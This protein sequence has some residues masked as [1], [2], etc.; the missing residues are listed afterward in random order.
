[1]RLL[2]DTTVGLRLA[3]EAIQSGQLDIACMHLAMSLTDARQL[4]PTSVKYRCLRGW[5]A[6]AIE[7]LE[8]R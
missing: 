8:Q 3:Q 7:A 5:I 1:M 4:D 6:Q 2:S